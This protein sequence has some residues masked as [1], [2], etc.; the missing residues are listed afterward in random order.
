MALYSLPLPSAGIHDAEPTM[1]GPNVIYICSAGHSGSTLLDLLLGSHSKIFSL[2]E[3]SH[4]P[5]NIALNTRCSCEAPVKDCAFWQSVANGIKQRLGI[6]MMSRPYDFYLGYFNAKVI[7]D[8]SNHTQLNRIVARVKQGLNYFDIKFSLDRF[9]NIFPSEK[10]ANRNNFLLFETVANNAGCDFVVDSSKSYIKAINLYRYNPEKVKVVLLTRDGRGVMQSNTKRGFDRNK[11][12]SAWK[13]YYTRAIPL[14]R[15]N[16]DSRQMHQ[17]KYEELAA[18]PELELK[19]LCAFLGLQFEHSML[20]FS[21]TVHHI[22]NGNDMRFS[23]SSE[24]RFDSAWQKNLTKT[25][26]DYFA[27]HAGQLNRELGYQ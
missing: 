8:K 16:V 2:G 7:V 17:V 12:V 1:T 20:D 21:D 18:A 24:I 3:I 26:A 27:S 23:H 10:I 15:S 11:S 9:T 6:D 22:T 25:D 14:L 4:L 19:K 5:K 13:K